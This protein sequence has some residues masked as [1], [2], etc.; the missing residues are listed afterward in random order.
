MTEP[1]L[2]FPLDQRASFRFWSDDK[3]RFGDLD[4]LGHVNNAAYSTFSESGRVAFVEA[5]GWPALGEAT[6]WVLARLTI[7]FRVP[8]RFPGRVEIGTRPLR[9]GRSSVTFGQGMFAGES[10]AATAVAVAVLADRRT[11]RSTPLPDELRRR[12]AG[13]SG[14]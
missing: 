6:M 2:P 4:P 8:L 12:L 7:D 5:L 1:D 11:E 10:C 9:I 3:I 14:G 13:Q